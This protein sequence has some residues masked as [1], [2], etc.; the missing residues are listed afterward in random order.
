MDRPERQREFSRSYRNEW[1][2]QKGDKETDCGPQQACTEA[3]QSRTDAD[4]GKVNQMQG[5]ENMGFDTYLSHLE[6]AK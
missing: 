2:C 3:Y 4:E 5:G 1:C 6:R